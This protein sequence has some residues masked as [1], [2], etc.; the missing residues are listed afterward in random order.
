MTKP[1][2]SD[3]SIK[4]FRIGYGTDVHRLVADRKLI[5]GGVEI[6]FEKGPLGH[7]DGDALIHA[8]CDALLGA[9]ALG[10]IGRHFPDTSPRWKGAPSLDFLRQVREL[11]E[12]KGYEIINVDSTIEIERPRMAPHIDSMRQEMARALT[13]HVDQVS[14]KAKTGEGMGEVGRGEAVRAEAVALI[15]RHH[16]V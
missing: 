10:D 11:V 4:A 3:N 12:A 8:I 9:T 1:E 5:L 14:V 7:S 13:I 6:P 16:N 15:R 2:I